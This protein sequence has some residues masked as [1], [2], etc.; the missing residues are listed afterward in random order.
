MRCLEV[1]ASVLLMLV[2]L[3]SE[4]QA[5]GQFDA[6]AALR[7]AIHWPV[8]EGLS[9]LEHW[10]VEY[11]PMDREWVQHVECFGKTTKPIEAQQIEAHQIEAHQ[12][13]AGR[14]VSNRRVQTWSFPIR[15]VL[16]QP[17]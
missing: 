12:I 7:H 3:G 9:A 6:A 15:S 16:I 1:T 10:I 2:G 17:G 14:I 13:E 11:S 4:P 8:A 5:F